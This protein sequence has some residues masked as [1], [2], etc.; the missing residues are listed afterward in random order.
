LQITNAKFPHKL[1]QKSA[2][3]CKENGQT[4]PTVHQN[5]TTND[6]PGA[7]PFR[8]DLSFRQFKI[9]WILGNNAEIRATWDS[10]T[11]WGIVN[12]LNIIASSNESTSR[13]ANPECAD[14]KNV[15]L[16]FPV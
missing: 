4:I 13:E 11:M 5:A 3:E 10:V 6:I 12:T 15:N 14:F 2:I 16:L 9:M 1:T 8:L 7:I